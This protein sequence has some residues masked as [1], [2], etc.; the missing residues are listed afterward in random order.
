MPFACYPLRYATLRSS[1]PDISLI[2]VHSKCGM[3]ICVVYDEHKLI[4][5]Q[6]IWFQSFPWFLCRLHTVLVCIIQLVCNLMNENCTCVRTHWYSSLLISIQLTIIYYSVALMA[7]LLT[8]SMIKGFTCV[9]G[10]LE[11]SNNLELKKTT[12]WSR[13]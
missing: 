5:F 12:R 1:N 6:C 4:H 8:R 3:H 9:N 2:F 11:N 13:D 7:I 10:N